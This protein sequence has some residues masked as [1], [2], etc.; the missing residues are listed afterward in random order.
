ML[1]KTGFVLVLLMALLQAFY[2][3]YAFID[4]AGF[5]E[6]R[7]TT[8]YSAQDADWVQIYA[9]RTLFIALIIGVLLYLQNYTLLICAALF[10]IV[11]PATDAWLAYQSGAANAVVGKHVATI[12]YLVIT[13]R[14]LLTVRRREA[15]TVQR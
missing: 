7:G 4:P 8:L 13:L 2:A 14:I 6:V 5:A 3:L 11:M 10:G 1:K 9:S 12:A 15:A